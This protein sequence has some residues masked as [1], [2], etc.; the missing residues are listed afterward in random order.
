[1]N[2][3]A[4]RDVVVVGAS[5]GG[6][7]ALQQLVSDLPA[8]LDAAV[9]VVIHLLPTAES[10]LPQIL[11][12]A[13]RLPAVPAV[14]GAPLD[15]GRIYIAPPDRHLMFHDSS[16]RVVRGPKENRHRPSIDVLFRSA[17]MT[18]GDCSIGVLL[19]GSDDDGT[20][21]LRT[22]KRHGG[23][24]VAQDPEDAESPRMPASAVVFAKPDFV[25]PLAEIG[26][27]LTDL[28]EGHRQK[29]GKPI[30]SK[31]ADRT[32]SM[33]EGRREDVKVLGTPSAFTC[34]DCNGTLWELEDGDVLQYRCR[35]GHAYSAESMLEAE[36]DALERAL[37]AA[38]RTLEE[39]AVVS[40]RIAHKSDVL[41]EQLRR[42]A[43]ER[44]EH[45]RIIRELLTGKLGQQG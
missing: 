15:T 17:A 23:V 21:G 39:S 9:C 18:F 31:P 45:A 3:Q 28:V 36:S 7:K 12:R 44:D 13:G 40:R 38:V 26:P 5:A 27:L 42:Q 24:T 10:L 20:A 6:V 43:V 37:W 35:V 33:A 22:I 34:P 2:P 16:L 8:D 19:T 1:M 14:N 30:R 4:G 41:R 25:K 32:L 11:S 29:R